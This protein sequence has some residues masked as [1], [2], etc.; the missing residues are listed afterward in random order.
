L[1]NITN[2]AS[3]SLGESCKV[4][5]SLYGP[6]STSTVAPSPNAEAEVAIS[7]IEMGATQS[8]QQHQQQQG[9]SMTNASVNSTTTVQSMFSGEL[10]TTVAS[11]SPFYDELK[12]ILDSSYFYDAIVARVI[13]CCLIGVAIV[14]Y[15]L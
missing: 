10:G 11:L 5:K 13:W 9:H 3:I 14:K 1:L 12:V 8:Q 7:F 15:G 4:R 2:A 6:S